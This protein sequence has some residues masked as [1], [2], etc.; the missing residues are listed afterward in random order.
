M[1]SRRI[2]RP[3][4]RDDSESL[5]IFAAFLLRSAAIDIAARFGN[6]VLAQKRRLRRKIPTKTSV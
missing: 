3:P 5:G 1:D 2:S 4:L 6:Q